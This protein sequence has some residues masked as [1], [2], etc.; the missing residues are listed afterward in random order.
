MTCP[1][2][3][4]CVSCRQLLFSSQVRNCFA[5]INQLLM[6]FKTNDM[7]YV[8]RS[9]GNYVTEYMLKSYLLLSQNWKILNK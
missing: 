6:Q 7:Q 2:H 4:L 9:D 3:N 5:L 8:A 1:Q